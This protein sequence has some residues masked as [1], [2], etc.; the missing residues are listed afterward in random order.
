[1]KAP[2]RFLLVALTAACL[3]AC[4]ATP[5]SVRPV[6][7]VLIG[8]STMARVTGYGDALCARFD[9]ATK[10]D[11]LARGGRS[12]KS[13]RAEGLWDQALLRVGERR[14]RTFVLIQFGHND[15]PGKA[16][17]STTLPEYAD[18][19]RRFIG[20]VRTAGALP[21]LVTPLTRR[22][23]RGGT[24]LDDLGPWA[25]ATAAVAQETKTALL[26]LH[27]DSMQAVSAMGALEALSLAELPPPDNAVAAAKTGTTVSVEKP[28]SAAP[29]VHVPA[30]DYTH[31]GPQGAEVFSAIVAREIRE[32]VPELAVTLR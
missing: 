3:C 11:N 4:A 5:K 19:L 1:L 9:A 6:H 24:L 30:F 17:R 27:R 13:Y 29:N 12:S 2:L 8:D 26:D 15:Q 21:V 22:S 25:E 14:Y 18:N 28:A 16:E 32:S 20:E 23:F 10:C 31:L 7:V